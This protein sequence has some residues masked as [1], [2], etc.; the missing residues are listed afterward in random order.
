MGWATP[1]GSQS[2]RACFARGAQRRVPLVRGESPI[3]Q[4]EKRYLFGF[5]YLHF[6]HLQIPIYKSFPTFI[7]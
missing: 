4:T 2:L 1:Q 6:T 5:S 7:F 3:R